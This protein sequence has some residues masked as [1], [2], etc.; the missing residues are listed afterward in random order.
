MILARDERTRSL[1]ERAFRERRVHKTYVCLVRGTPEPAQATLNAYLKKDARTATVR[2]TDT[3]ARGALPIVTEY[4]VLE[5]GECCRLAV[6]LHTGR[7]H[8]IRAH[9]AH[10]G[11][12]ILG[13]DKYGDRAWN[14]AMRANRL[15]LTATE[16]EFSL[17]GELSYLNGKRF[18]LKPTF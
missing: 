18:S 15:M 1:M 7:T 11:H 10:V 3:P 17:E 6:T 14:K 8:Q 12:P 4:R 9:L 5:A 2:V 16:L 13:D